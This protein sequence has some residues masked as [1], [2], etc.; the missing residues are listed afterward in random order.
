MFLPQLISE[1]LTSW[2]N[3]HIDMYVYIITFLFF[4]PSILLQLGG[5]VMVPEFANP[6]YLAYAP[7]SQP[8][9]YIILSF[10]M[11]II[12]FIRLLYADSKIFELKE[13]KTYKENPDDKVIDIVGKKYRKYC[14]TDIL[15]RGRRCPQ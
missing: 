15:F 2:F 6:T 7:F 5:N 10:G 4:G 12:Y 9:A 3:I 11:G 1:F 13:K 8:W 14:F